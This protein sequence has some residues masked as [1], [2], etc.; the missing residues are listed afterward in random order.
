M[1]DSIENQSKLRNVNWSMDILPTGTNDTT[2]IAIDTL[3]PTNSLSVADVSTTNQ[4]VTYS[5]SLWTILLM[6]TWGPA[7][8]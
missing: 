8:S 6:C 1:F 4:T 7:I 3:T 5:L 2:P